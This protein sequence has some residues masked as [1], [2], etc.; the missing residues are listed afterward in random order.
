MVAERLDLMSDRLEKRMDAGEPRTSAVLAVLSEVIKASKKCTVL[1]D[2]AYNE[3]TNM[4]GKNSM[5]PLV[6]A[7]HDVFV[8]RTF[9]KLYGLAGMRVGY[10]IASPETS[11]KMRMYG[12][13]N[14]AMN[15]AGVAAAIA[16][17]DDFDFLNY[18]K[19]KIQEARG[20]IEDAVKENGLTAAPS[21]TSFVFVNLGKL[22]AEEF[23]QEMAKHNVLIRG[24]YQ[25]YTNWSRVSCGKIHDVQQYVSALP[26]VLAALKA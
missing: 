25:D 23:R 5:I 4:P 13:G 16:S 21:E 22:N 24:I 11:D 2:E 20:M 26:T 7:G 8:A 10:M 3:I 19:S 6:K 17:Y 1:V 9:S 12:L 18:S 15:Q 14:Y